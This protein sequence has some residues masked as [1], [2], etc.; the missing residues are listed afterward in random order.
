MAPALQKSKV[1]LEKRMLH[2]SLEHKLHERPKPTEL[3][4]QGILTGEEKKNRSDFQ[5]KKSLIKCR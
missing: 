3:V 1:E 5:K 4:E 2:D